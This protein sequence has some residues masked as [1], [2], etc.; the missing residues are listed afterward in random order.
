ML[1]MEVK[2]GED[3]ARANAESVT[4]PFNRASKI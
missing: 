3:V 1:Q 4:V 2:E